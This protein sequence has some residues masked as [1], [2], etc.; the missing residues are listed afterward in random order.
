MGV[1]QLDELNG[2]RQ[3]ISIHLHP[4]TFYIYCSSL[5]LE[6][7]YTQT[8]EEEDDETG[9]MP[10]LGELRMRKKRK[11]ARRVSVA[12]AAEDG[13]RK[14]SRIR[15]SIVESS[16]RRGSMAQKGEF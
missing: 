13:I 14:A 16:R 2:F 9:L 7:V 12:N 11:G 5:Q 3:A 1:F 10:D 6:D 15:A 4:I 8:N